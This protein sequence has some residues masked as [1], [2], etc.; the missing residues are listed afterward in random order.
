MKT[1]P[2]ITEVFAA[3]AGSEDEIN[4]RVFQLF[5]LTPD[6]IKQLQREVEH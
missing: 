2:W 3:I 1:M 4:A 6:E 5:K